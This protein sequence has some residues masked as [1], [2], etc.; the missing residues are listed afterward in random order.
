MNVTTFTKSSQLWGHKNARKIGPA[1]KN[2]QKAN[3]YL[4]GVLHHIKHRIL[5]KLMYGIYL[6]KKKLG[7]V[8]L[9][10]VRHT[11]ERHRQTETGMMGNTFKWYQ[12][13]NRGII[14]YYLFFNKK[15][16]HMIQTP[17]G[18][19]LCTVKCEAFLIPLL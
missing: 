8:G 1:K 14:F 7:S 10:S 6:K 18:T 17:S 4:H 13:G 11:L 9:K 12:K 2:L 15:F 5:W 3:T 19:E 16:P